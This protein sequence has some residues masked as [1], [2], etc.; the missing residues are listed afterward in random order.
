M[1]IL[2]DQIDIITSFYAL[3]GPLF[4]SRFYTSEELEYGFDKRFTIGNRA[5]TLLKEMGYLHLQGTWPDSV[6]HG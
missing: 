3:I 1:S 5:L 6:G 2:P 4:P